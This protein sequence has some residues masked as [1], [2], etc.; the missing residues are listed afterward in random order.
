LRY[1]FETYEIY[2]EDIYDLMDED[3]IEERVKLEI[4][5]GRDG[6]YVLKDL[7]QIEL[8]TKACA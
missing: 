4:R 5:E 6:N 7:T 8:K 2:N 1:Y 3:S